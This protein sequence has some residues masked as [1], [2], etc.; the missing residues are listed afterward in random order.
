MTG[1]VRVRSF[2]VGA[3]ALQLGVALVVG[4]PL[5]APAVASAG[6][7]PEASPALLTTTPTGR[8]LATTAAARAAATGQRTEITELTTATRRIFANPD[9]SYTLEQ[10]TVP[11]RAGVDEPAQTVNLGRSAWAM[12]DR[13]FP[14]QAYWLGGGETSAKVGHVDTAGV[15]HT[16]RSF[17][18]FDVTALAGKQILDARFDTFESWSYSCTAREVQ[19]WAT[20]P[21]GPTTT[22][23]NQ[24]ALDQ[25][26]DARS[27][28][29]GFGAACPGKWLSF[30]VDAAVA[31]SAELGNATTTL[32][33]R[34]GNE[35]D[36]VAWK[37]FVPDNVALVVTFTG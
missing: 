4:S 6:T 14:D 7:G 29:A 24:P 13:Y 5:A 16:A 30:D 22:W 20:G 37:R 28:A 10:H 31:R 11:V 15:S 1:R 32:M 33:L 25:L 8:T 17:F 27:A 36:P 34:A 12:V 9:G 35:E 2:V 21:I 26:L 23:R 19:L 3:L 18:Q